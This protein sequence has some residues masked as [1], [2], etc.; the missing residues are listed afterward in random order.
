MHLGPIQTRPNLDLILPR[1]RHILG[2]NQ[3][4]LGSESDWVLIFKNIPRSC[5][6]WLECHGSQFQN[7]RRQN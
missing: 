3:V 4:H 1:L 5:L 2:Q 6:C 7:Q